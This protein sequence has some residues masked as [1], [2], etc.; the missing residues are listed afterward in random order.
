MAKTNKLKFMVSI[1]ADL[2]EWL[3]KSG[4]AARR[5]NKRAG[6]STIINMVLRERYRRSRKLLL[7]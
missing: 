1:D 4:Q 5:S 2:A 3:M 7:A 6:R